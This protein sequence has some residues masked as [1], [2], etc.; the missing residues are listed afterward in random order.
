MHPRKQLVESNTALFSRMKAQYHHCKIILLIIDV[1][2]WL[3]I[4]MFSCIRKNIRK[5]C[6]EGSKIQYLRK[7]F[8]KWHNDNFFVFLYI[9]LLTNGG[10][11]DNGIKLVSLW[12]PKDNSCLIKFRCNKLNCSS[13]TKISSR[14]SS[15]TGAK[16]LSH[17]LKAVIFRKKKESS[18]YDTVPWLNIGEN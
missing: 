2:S 3:I 18:D 15:G 14:T 7:T 1:P 4:R 17:L 6:H 13:C 5:I 10:K 8:F 12:Y 11:K 9:K 16:Q